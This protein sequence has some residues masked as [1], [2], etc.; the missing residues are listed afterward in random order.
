MEL[1]KALSGGRE[2][3]LTDELIL[4]WDHMGREH[5]LGQEVLDVGSEINRTSSSDNKTWHGR[6][7]AIGTL[8]SR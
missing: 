1:L 2:R 4:E 6:R 8:V 5:E 3:V 7:G